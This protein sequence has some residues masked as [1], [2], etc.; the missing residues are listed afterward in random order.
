MRGKGNVFKE[1]D[2]IEKNVIFR[3]RGYLCGIAWT[4]AGAVAFQ[5]ERERPITLTRGAFRA[6]S[7]W[8]S[9]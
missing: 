6:P 9:V 4:R 5:Y 1:R 8:T 3:E 7:D 2:R